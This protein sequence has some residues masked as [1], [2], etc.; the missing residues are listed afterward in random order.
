HARRV[1]VA[2]APVPGAA[3]QIHRFHPADARA[4]PGLLAHGGGAMTRHAFTLAP[5]HPALAGHFPGAPLVP[6]AVPVEHVHDAI[7]VAGAP[8]RLPRVEFLRPLLPGEPAEVS[9]EPMPEGDNGAR[10]WR[11][12]VHRGDALLATGEVVQ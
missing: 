11:F 2:P 6:G 12:R 9:L 5:D 10:R 1:R 7:G 4:G 8:L 3:P